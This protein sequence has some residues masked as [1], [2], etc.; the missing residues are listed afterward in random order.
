MINSILVIN[1]RINYTYKQT[2]ISLSRG[3]TIIEYGL[4]DYNK[5]SFK[6]MQSTDQRWSTKL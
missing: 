5:W 6:G 4:H 1:D 3:K 2:D